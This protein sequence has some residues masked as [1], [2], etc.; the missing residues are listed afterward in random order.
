M[1][2][3]TGVNEISLNEYINI[4]PNP[5]TGMI[6]IECN[7]PGGEYEMRMTDVLGQE[8]FS[9]KIHVS[10]NYSRTMNMYNYSSGVYILSI[11]GENSITQKKIILNK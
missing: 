6:Q 4:Y 5:T 11:I 8:M 7:I 10:G 3:L 2:Q 1:S 9:E